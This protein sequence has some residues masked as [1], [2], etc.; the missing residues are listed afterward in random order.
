[1]CTFKLNSADPAN[2]LKRHYFIP[3][4]WASTEALDQCCMLDD[5]TLLLPKDGE[6]A[7]I[8]S[9]LADPEW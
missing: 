4:D 2:G 7:V 6:V 3:R 5:G 9:A 1:M 8:T